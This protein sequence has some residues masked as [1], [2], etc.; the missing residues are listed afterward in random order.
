MGLDFRFAFLFAFYIVLPR[1]PVVRKKLT[2]LLNNQA[3]Y[4]YLRAFMFSSVFL[5]A[6][7]GLCGVHTI[8]MQRTRLPLCSSILPSPTE[9]VKEMEYNIPCV[10]MINNILSWLLMHS[11]SGICEL[12]F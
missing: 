10:G 3:I 6:E 5:G 2:G 1:N 7:L 4:R 8:G 11:V 9:S 12:R